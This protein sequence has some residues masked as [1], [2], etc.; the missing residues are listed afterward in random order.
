MFCASNERFVGWIEVNDGSAAGRARDPDRIFKQSPLYSYSVDRIDGGPHV[1]CKTLKV[2]N[3]LFDILEPVMKQSYF[4]EGVMR[5][6]KEPHVL[7][8]DL[9]NVVDDILSEDSLTIV[10]ANSKKS[11]YG[12]RVNSSDNKSSAFSLLLLKDI[13]SIGWHYVEDANE[14]M[15]VLTLSMPD[16]RGRKHIFDLCF[17]SQ[18]RMHMYLH[19]SISLYCSYNMYIAA[20][21]SRTTNPNTYSLI[22]LHHIQH[23]QQA[24]RM[25]HMSTQTGSSSTTGTGST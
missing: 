13:E 17:D 12:S 4:L 3:N 20:L 8:R 25:Q 5:G 16:A 1:D 11:K 24:S 19:T 23:T 15:S 10:K 14:D 9:Q 7:A 18:V 6:T 2:D 22:H 21:L